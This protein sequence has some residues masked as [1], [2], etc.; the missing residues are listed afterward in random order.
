MP[1]SESFQFLHH[2]DHPVA[3]AIDL[4]LCPP[5]TED[6]VLVREPCCVH[7]AAAG[8]DP[9]VG[10]DGRHFVRCPHGLRLHT[11][12]HDPVRDALVRLLDHALGRARVIAERPADQRAIRE[13]MEHHGV[14]LRHRPDIVL[15][16]FDGPRSYVLIDV[17]TFDPAGVTWIT[18]RHTDTVRLAAHAW[19]ESTF[20]PAQ[21]FG[22]GASGAPRG[23]G[24]GP[25]LR[26][27]TFAVSIYGAL[28]RQAQE[29]LRA[30]A[31]RCGRSVPYS[32][33][34]EASWAAPSFAPFVR[35]AITLAVR[36]AL[37]M[38][39]CES[40]VTRETA[41]RFSPPEAPQYEEGSGFDMPGEDE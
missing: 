32:L 8:R 26:L 2:T 4:L 36:R 22:P 25:R 18:R 13:W 3:S 12:V 38:A 1:V 16:G 31:T 23:D 33:L 10:F 11:S 9:S 28:G 35:M 30:V 27:L 20:A 29:L 37:A 6:G 19:L 34:D 24:P 14:G 7:C 40:L 15:V 39:V 41:A 5:C 21:Y 17:K